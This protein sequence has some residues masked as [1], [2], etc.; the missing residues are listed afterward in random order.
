M[1]IFSTLSLLS[2]LVMGCELEEFPSQF[3]PTCTTKPT[4]DFTLD[5]TNCEAPCTVTITNNTAGA[6][7]FQWDFGDGATSTLQ[8][9]STHIFESEGD[10]EIQLI[11]TDGASCKDTTSLTVS[12]TPG[13]WQ[14]FTDPRNGKKYRTIWIDV[15][16]G[17]NAAKAGNLWFA[18]NLDMDT[19]FSTC[20]ADSAVN[21]DTFGRLYDEFSL[22]NA[23]PNGW[24]L[25]T[26]EEW[27][28][29]FKTYGFTEVLT[30][31][32]PIYNGDISVMLPGGASGMEILPGGLRFNF[33]YSGKG[34]NAGFWA[35]TGDHTF[36]NQ[37][38][39]ASIFFNAVQGNPDP[40]WQFYVR[41]VKN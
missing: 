3:A 12:V 41:L 24:H 26:K 20:Y 11:A 2:I 9:P 22:A 16:G 17:H 8:N 7:S 19:G 40:D 4:A 33:E 32:G 13:L 28:N 6:T 30:S 31:N 14:L 37:S 39:G 34:E 21:C 18:D 36:I 25:A 15:D 35:G 5:K 27:S 38:G 23:I 10:Y 29:L 1:S